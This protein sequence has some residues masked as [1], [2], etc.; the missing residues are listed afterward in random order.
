VHRLDV[1]T[2]GLMVV[3]KSETAYSRCKRGVQGARGRQAS[4]TRSSRA[5]RPVAGTIDA[6]IDRHP[7]HDYKWA[8][9]SA[10]GRASRSTTRSRRS[11]RP[12]C[13][14]SIWRPGGT[15]QIRVHMAALRHPCVGDLMYGADPTLAAR[16]G[17]TRSGCTPGRCRSSIRAPVRWSASTATTRPTWPPRWPS[18]GD[19]W[20]RTSRSRR[21]NHDP[22]ARIDRGDRTQAGPR[23]DPRQPRGAAL[24]VRPLTVVASALV[25]AVV[26]TG[27]WRLVRPAPEAATRAPPR[28]GWGARRGLG[29]ALHRGVP[30]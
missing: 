25:L 3:A 26:A 16:L 2:T 28:Y 19:P 11:R 6:P 22:L 10:G 30:G 4:T 29:A 21:G 12:A 17:L 9:V 8:V 20:T 5:T 15:H 23:T 1:G 18:C 24:A 13:S 7:T 14:R 27:I